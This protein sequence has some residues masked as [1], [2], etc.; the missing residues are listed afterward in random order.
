MRTVYRMRVSSRG[1]VVIPRP[2]R[3]RVG[4]EGGDEVSV[5]A[6]DREMVAAEKVEATEFEMAMARISRHLDDLGVTEEDLQRALREVRH[7][8]YEERYGTHG[9][10]QAVS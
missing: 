1:Q 6:V 7:E 4:L 5:Q 2:V 9:R 8:R 10:K 3:E